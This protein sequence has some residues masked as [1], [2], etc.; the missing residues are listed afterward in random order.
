MAAKAEAMVGG[1]LGSTRRSG[2][3][4]VVWRRKRARWGGE[5]VGFFSDSSHG[6]VNERI[7]RLVRGRESSEARLAQRDGGT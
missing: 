2:A 5:Q 6:G 4:R 3:W 7:G 1:I